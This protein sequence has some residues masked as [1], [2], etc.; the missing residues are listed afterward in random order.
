M[1]L[2]KYC[3]IKDND[4]ME[5]AVELGVQYIGFVVD[6][7][8]SPRSISLLEFRKKSEWLRK[9][10]AGNYKIVAVTVNMPSTKLDWLIKGKMADVIQLHGNENLKT[11]RKLKTQIETWKAIPQNFKIREREI[12]DIAA[13]VNMVLLDSGSAL[14]KANGSSGVFRKYSSY[15][16]WIK[17]GIPV[18]LSGGINATN[19]AEFIAIYNPAVID[20]S[21]GIEL[22]PGKKSKRKMKEFM[23]VIARYDAER[24]KNQ[25]K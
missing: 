13:A 1:T 14:E 19:V 21:S 12:P 23:D 10:F 22:S 17:K 9:E 11:C 8:V 3:G 18:V 4:S 20:V 7:P 2:I 16:R 6:Y 24:L 5:Y 15:E 25:D